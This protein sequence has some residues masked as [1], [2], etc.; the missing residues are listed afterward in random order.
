[1]KKDVTAIITLVVAPSVGR[2]LKAMRV[3]ALISIFGH[4]V[5]GPTNA[6]ANGIAQAIVMII[7]AAVA[8][9]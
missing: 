8:V 1:M 2:L 7:N 3:V 5:V 6:H 9:D 4:V